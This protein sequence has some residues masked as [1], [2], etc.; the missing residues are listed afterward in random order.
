MRVA[1]ILLKEAGEINK[2]MWG[3]PESEKKDTMK[4]ASEMGC[5]KPEDLF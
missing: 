3:D 4:Q 1:K 2:M 5:K